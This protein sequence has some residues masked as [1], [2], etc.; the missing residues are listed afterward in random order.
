MSISIEKTFDKILYF[1]L[2]KTVSKLE[3]SF[4][5]VTMSVDEKLIASI[6]L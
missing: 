6:I 3:V 1:L 5:I 4:L 2:Q